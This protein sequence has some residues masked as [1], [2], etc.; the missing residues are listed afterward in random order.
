MTLLEAKEITVSYYGDIEI[1]KD[2]SLN[3]KKGQITSI[4]GPNG[5]G[6]STLLKSLYGLLRPKKGRVLLNNKDITKRKV[7]EFIGLGITYVPQLRSI[8]PDLTVEENLQLGTWIFKK[9]TARVKESIE[10]IYTRFPLLFKK[11]RDK[12]GLLSGGQQKILEIGRSLLTDPK[13]CLFDE[14]TATLAPRIAEE[15]YSTILDLKKEN[16]TIVMVD[17][18]IKQAFEI[19]DQIYVLELGK[20]KANGTRE[21]FEGGLKEIIKGWLD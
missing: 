14:P 12:A 15:I 10:K 6:K 17:Q 19:S 5:A 7:H 11:K 21:D 2:V 16:I 18:R 4:I 9:D 3:V 20:N 8:F 13:I 1:L